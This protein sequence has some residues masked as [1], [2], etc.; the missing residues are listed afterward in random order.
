MLDALIHSSYLLFVHSANKR[1]ETHPPRAPMVEMQWQEWHD[2]LPDEPRP[3]ADGEVNSDGLPQCGKLQ[4]A[5]AE[6]KACQK[7]GL[8]PM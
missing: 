5:Q 6:T 3:L 4:E 2:D 1:A 7:E 8:S